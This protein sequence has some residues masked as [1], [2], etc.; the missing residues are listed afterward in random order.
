LKSHPDIRIEPHAVYFGGSLLRRQ[1]QGFRAGLFV[2]VLGL[3]GSL[4]EEQIGADRRP[5]DGDN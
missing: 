2:L 4:P 5:E 3:L 1:H